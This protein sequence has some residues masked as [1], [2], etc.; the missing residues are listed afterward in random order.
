MSQA[1]PSPALRDN[2][3]FTVEELFKFSF[4]EGPHS[5]RSM[6]FSGLLRGLASGFGDPSIRAE[7]DAIPTRHRVAG[8][9]EIPEDVLMKEVPS[10]LLEFL[11][12][13]LRNLEDV[14]LPD[15]YSDQCVAHACVESL[16]LRGM[17]PQFLKLCGLKGVRDEDDALEEL[18]GHAH[19][20]Y[21]AV[22]VIR[23]RKGPNF[24]GLRSRLLELESRYALMSGDAS[25]QL[26]QAARAISDVKRDASDEHVLEIGAHLISVLADGC[27]DGAAEL[28][29]ENDDYVYLK[30]RY[31]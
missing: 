11:A 23:V 31:A 27:L 16:G 21:G 5:R 10:M 22:A 30:Y 17:L 15:A 9:H 3:P 20:N 29:A 2:S 7:L 25:S 28:A 1:S 26:C 8:L 18:S 14:T 13:E 19:G 6:A 4:E 24:Q 12:Q